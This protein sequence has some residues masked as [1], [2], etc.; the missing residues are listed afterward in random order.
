[1][2]QFEMVV[3]EISKM[4]RGGNSV[5][6]TT[7]DDNGSTWWESN[8][9]GYSIEREQMGVIVSSYYVWYH[10]FIVL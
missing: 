4:W 5:G 7:N 10:L 8:L 1:M 2:G 3:L 9:G 6:A